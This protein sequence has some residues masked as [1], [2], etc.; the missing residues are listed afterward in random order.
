[1]SLQGSHSTPQPPHGRQHP[2]PSPCQPAPWHC[3][4][5]TLIFRGKPGFFWR[6][7][8]G[9]QVLPTPSTEEDLRAAFTLP[10]LP[11]AAAALRGQG[12]GLPPSQGRAAL[13]GGTTIPRGDLP[14]IGTPQKRG[15]GGKEGLNPTLKPPNGWPPP[16]EAC[17]ALRGLAR[18]RPAPQGRDAAHRRSHP[19][20]PRRTAPRGPSPAAGHRLPRLGRAL[21]A[22][23]A[24]VAA[25]PR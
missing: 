3:P 1:M 4:I 7:V 24:E 23:G 13:A 12:R 21:R 6:G 8:E 11:G 15:K 22:A 5:P 17:P 14:S 19:S 20:P 16:G 9:G 2:S 10:P 25:S 18:R